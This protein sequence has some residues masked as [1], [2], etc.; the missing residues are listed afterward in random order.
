MRLFSWNVNG[1]RAAERKGI[2]D[3]IA[4]EKPDV[5]CVQETKA[6]PD[7]LSEALLHEHGY[8]VVWAS[9]EKAGYSGVATFSREEPEVLSVG[10]GEHQFDREGRSIFTRHGDFILYNGY[11]PNGQRDHARVP[12]KMDFY[13]KLLERVNEYRKAG[14]PMVLCG[15][16]NTAHKPADLARPKANKRTSGFLEEEREMIDVFLEAGFADAFR[17]RYPDKEGA[18]TWWSNRRGARERNVGWRIDYHMVSEDLMPRVVDVR[19]HANT[20]GSDHCPI[21][22]ELS[23][24]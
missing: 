9:A 22:L 4:R 15:D 24:K 18:Y 21:E 2:L 1:I 19:I 6:R 8:H 14:H 3:W 5:L 7:Q 13:R 20:L 23:T 17:E 11:F 12:Y 16:W 10:L